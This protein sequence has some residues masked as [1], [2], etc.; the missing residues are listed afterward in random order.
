MKK[1]EECKFG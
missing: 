1:G